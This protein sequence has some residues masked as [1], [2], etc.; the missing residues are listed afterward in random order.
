MVLGALLLGLAFFVFYRPVEIEDNWW[1]LS[2]GRWMVEHRSVPHADTFPLLDEQKPWILTQWLGSLFFYEAYALGGMEGLKVFRLFVFLVVLGIYFFYARPKIPFVL[3]AFLIFLIEYGLMGR[4][5]LRPDIFNYIFLQLLLILL[6]KYEDTKDRRVLWPVLALGVVWGNMHLGSFVYGYVLIFLFLAAAI[7][8]RVIAK[9][10]GRTAFDLSVLFVLYAFTF[11]VSPYSLQAGLYPFKVFFVPDFIHV[12]KFAGMMQEALA[13]KYIFSP[14]GFWVLL[15]A[16]AAVAG[17]VFNKRDRLLHALLFIGPFFLF[18][19]G[20]RA[21]GFFVITAAYVI[22]RCA[23][24]C[25]FFEFWKS[26]RHAR[27]VDAGIALALALILTAHIVGG[28]TERVYANGRFQQVYDLDA[29]PR[30]PFD[31]IVFLKKRGISGVVVT[32]DN[33]GSFLLWQGYPEMRPFIDGRQIHPEYFFKQTAILKDPSGWPQL[34]GEFD[35]KIV[36]LDLSNASSM[37]F[38]R[39]LRQDRNWQLIFLKGVNVVFVRRGVFSLDEKT[40]RFEERLSQE[41]VN[42]EEWGALRQGL[43]DQQSGTRKGLRYNEVL[44][45]AI[46]LSELGFKAAAVRALTRARQISDDAQVRQAI[47]SISR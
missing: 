16:A 24:Q 40:D 14:A 45:H 44:E 35:L 32:N 26:Y 29:D 46:S 20:G 19:K 11:A 15:L 13:P 6:F 31:A 25:R 2:V 36:M 18:L 27:L 21:S 37:R 10:E 7:V 12:Y 23:A 39:Y 17:I 30:L 5:L 22:V 38:A 33:Y 8:R 43:L 4:V 3:L 9:E 47:L 42:A 41:A 1:H 28:L 34:A